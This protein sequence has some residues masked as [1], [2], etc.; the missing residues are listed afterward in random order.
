MPL[1]TERFNA[2]LIVCHGCIISFSCCSKS[3]GA[4]TLSSMG[5]RSTFKF[6]LE[7]YCRRSL[8]RLHQVWVVASVTKLHAIGSCKYFER[9]LLSGDKIYRC[10]NTAIVHTPTDSSLVKLLR[11]LLEFLCLAMEEIKTNFLQVCLS[12]RMHQH[13]TLNWLP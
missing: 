1:C 10:F 8:D 13:L 5:Q 4:K 11:L 7:M 2:H 12:V 9:L 6:G 3:K